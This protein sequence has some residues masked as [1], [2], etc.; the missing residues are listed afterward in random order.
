MGVAGPHEMVPPI[1]ELW[2][3]LTA[4]R[5]EMLFIAKYPVWYCRFSYRVYPSFKAL[6]PYLKPLPLIISFPL[7]VI[8]LW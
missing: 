3:G 1:D 6:D 7:K 4:L 8:T 2:S 5:H